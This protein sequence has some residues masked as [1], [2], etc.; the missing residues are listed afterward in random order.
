MNKLFT[1]QP[2]PNIQEFVSHVEEF[3]P[4]ATS[5]SYKYSHPFLIHV[6]IEGQRAYIEARKGSEDMLLFG[7]Q[8]WIKKYLLTPIEQW[9]I[10]EVRI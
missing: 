5:D 6:D 2:L 4:I 3:N 7:L 8:A 10:S 9:M 1:Q